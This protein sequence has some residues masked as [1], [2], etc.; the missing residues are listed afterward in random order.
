M[1]QTY[2]Y[3]R[4]GAPLLTWK[5]GPPYQTRAAD[6]KSLGSLGDPTVTL[7]LPRPGSPEPVGGCGCGGDAVVIDV[8][9]PSFVVGALVG[10]L[11]L[12]KLWKGGSS[13]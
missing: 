1:K 4:T 3:Q 9:S 13:T 2:A 10:F 6:A 11:L 5:H 7:P 12:P 8:M